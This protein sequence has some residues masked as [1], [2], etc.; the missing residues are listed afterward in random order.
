[1]SIII[2]YWTNLLIVCCNCR[3]GIIHSQCH[4][5]LIALHKLSHTCIH[6]CLPTKL[7]LS[8]ALLAFI[9]HCA[10]TNIISKYYKLIHSIYIHPYLLEI[11]KKLFLLQSVNFNTMTCNADL[12]FLCKLTMNM[13]QY[14]PPFRCQ[15]V[16]GYFPP[17]RR[18]GGTWQM[19]VGKKVDSSSHYNILYSYDDWC[20][21]VI[22]TH[23]TVK[24]TSVVVWIVV[25]LCPT[26]P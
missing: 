25:S 16:K 10:W 21:I 8:V 3:F 5:L 4:C 7:W 24:T 18:E 19:Y 23:S 2:S 26:A 12:I 13:G 15:N 6:T 14:H 11:W 1:M 9:P 20:I 22:Q 17:G